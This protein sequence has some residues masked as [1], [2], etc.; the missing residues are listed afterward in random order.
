ML[1]Q[2]SDHR[3]LAAVE[4]PLV[5]PDHDRVPAAIRVGQRGDHLSG[6]RAAAPRHRP[7]L[8]D[9]GEPGHDPPVAADERLGLGYPRALQGQ[10][11]V[12]PPRM[13]SSSS[14]PPPQA[15]LT[16]LAWH[17]APQML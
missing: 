7:A 1:E 3:V 11:L 14:W 8:P 15:S 10:F 12:S 17:R 9:V 4:R 2:R 13:L 5:L 6:L 16:A